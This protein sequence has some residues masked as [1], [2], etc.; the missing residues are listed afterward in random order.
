[1]S[2]LTLCGPLDYSLLDSSDHEISQGK[3]LD[4]LVLLKSQGRKVLQTILQQLEPVKWAQLLLRQAQKNKK[5]EMDHQM[6]FSHPYFL[7][8]CQSCWACCL[9]KKCTCTSFNLEYSSSRKEGKL[10]SPQYKQENGIYYAR[11]WIHG[12]AI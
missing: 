11:Q 8:F 7:A 1:M 10:E 4:N 12:V 9:H 5:T 2:C 6:Y 3:I